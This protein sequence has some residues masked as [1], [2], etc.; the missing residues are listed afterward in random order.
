[1]CV[2]GSFTSVYIVS[3]AGIKKVDDVMSSDNQVSVPMITSADTVSI[4]TAMFL[5]VL[6]IL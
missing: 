2:C 6:L 4:N 3:Y 5:P 1:M